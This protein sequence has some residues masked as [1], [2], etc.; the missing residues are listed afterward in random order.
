MNFVEKIVSAVT[1][2]IQPTIKTVIWLMKLMLPITLLVSILDYMGVILIVS[3]FVEPLFRLMGLGGEAAIVFITSS[4]A[5]IYAAIGVMAGLGFELREVTIMATMCLICHNLIIETKVQNKAGSSYGYILFIRIFFGL[6]A[7][8]LLNLIIPKDMAGALYM[9]EMAQK[10]STWVEVFVFWAQTIIPLLGKV[11]LFVSLLN[12]LQGILKE[13]KLIDML[14]KPMQPFM[15]VLG[16]PY[17]TTFLWI[18]VNTLGLAYGG[19]VMSS[20]MEKGEIAHRDAQL[21]NTS[22]AMNHSMLEDSLLF[23]ALGVGVWWVLLPRLV[24]AIILTWIMKFYYNFQD[25]KTTKLQN[26]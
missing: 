7:G 20:E 3:D 19:M 9:P 11:L 1:K 12:I 2:S 13:F 17:S 6:F 21:L 18:V 8:F 16:L 26:S 25:K 22:A 24:I 10:P 4:F 15:K 23:M 5:S 14:L